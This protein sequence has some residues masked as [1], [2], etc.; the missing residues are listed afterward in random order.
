[1]AGFFVSVVSDD[2]GASPAGSFGCSTTDCGRRVTVEV[3]VRQ[4]GVIKDRVGKYVRY[5][6]ASLAIS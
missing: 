3:G 1:V 2:M 6:A 4:S 5:R